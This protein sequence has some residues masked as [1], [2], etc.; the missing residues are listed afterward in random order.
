[1]R[2]T[3]LTIG[4]GFPCLSGLGFALGLA[5]TSTACG[6][7]AASGVVSPA[8]PED[9][10]SLSSRARAALEGGDL[11]AAWRA[12]SRALDLSADDASAQDVAARVALARGD[13]EGAVRVLRRATAPVLVRLRARARFRRGELAAAAE[14]LASVEDR[15]PVDGWAVAVLPI[16]RAGSGMEL[17]RLEGAGETV[18]P[19]VPDVPVPVVAIVIDG[20]TVNALVATSADLTILDDGVRESSGIADR[21]ELGG[22][23]VQRVPVLVRDLDEVSSQ[24]GVPLGAVLGI[25]LLLR[26]GATLDGR[27]R[28][29]VLRRERDDGPM[30]GAAIPFVTLGGTFLAVRAEV[31]GRTSGWLTVDSAG[32][33]PVAVSDVTTAHLRWTADDVTTVPGAPSGRVMLGRIRS[34]RMAEVELADLPALTGLVPAELPDL[35]GVPVAGM[36]GSALWMQLRI[37]LDP[38]DRSIHVE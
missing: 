16:A 10:A 28:R 11:E 15:D 7:S 2:S 22:V 34:L 1:M 12:S 30:A 26:L 17:Y 35:A 21:L 20:R 27:E 14:D 18:L 25:D 24:V 4:P 19:F 32:L 29:L 8:E 36:L 13:D 37:T 31:D 3:Q 23:S 6:A 9:I 5:M 33:F 38:R